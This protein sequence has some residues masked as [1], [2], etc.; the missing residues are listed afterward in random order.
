MVLPEWQPAKLLSGIALRRGTQLTIYR[1]PFDCASLPVGSLSGGDSGE[2][3]AGETSFLLT[4]P[5]TAAAFALSRP[6]SLADIQSS[7]AVSGLLKRGGCNSEGS[8]KGAGLTCTYSRRSARKMNSHYIHVVGPPQDTT[9]EVVHTMNAHAQGLNPVS[10]R[11]KAV[12]AACGGYL[13]YTPSIRE[14]ANATGRT[15]TLMMP[16][17]VGRGYGSLLIPIKVCL[18]TVSINSSRGFK[19]LH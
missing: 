1:K 15:E 3:Q 7:P 18:D 13:K 6:S 11:R 16:V 12:E 14:E 9:S 8:I 4:F 19:A 5:F 2:H 10:T 17:S